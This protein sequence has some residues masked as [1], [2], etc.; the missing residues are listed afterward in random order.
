VYTDPDDQS[1][2]IYLRGLIS[3]LQSTHSPPFVFIHS[4]DFFGD[5]GLEPAVIRREK[6]LDAQCIRIKRALGNFHVS[7]GSVL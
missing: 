4:V 5:L 6:T 2:W 3:V 1:P 7:Q